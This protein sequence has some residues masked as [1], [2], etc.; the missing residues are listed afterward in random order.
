MKV[1]MTR[2]LGGGVSG[3]WSGLWAGTLDN[4]ISILYAIHIHL[5]I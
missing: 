3:Q 2:T 4:N 5:N 1:D